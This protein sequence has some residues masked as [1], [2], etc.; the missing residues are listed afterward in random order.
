MA[1]ARPEF[2]LAVIGAGPA[3]SSAAIT[4]ARSGARVVL[5]EAGEFPRHKVCG[6][7]VSAE[8]LDILRDLLQGVSDAGDKLRDAPAIEGVRFLVERACTSAAVSPA[9]LSLPRYDL[10]NLLWQAAQQAG[11]V[12]KSN[13]HVRTIEGNGP[14]E[15]ETSKGQIVASAVVVA[16]G[17]WSRFRPKGAV[18]AGPKWVGLKAHYREEDPSGSSDL[19]FFEYGYCG[20]QPV[21]PGVVNACAM[22]RSDRATSLQEVFA[23]HPALAQRSRKWEPLMEPVTTAPLIYRTPEPVRENLIFVGDAAAF[24]DPFVG[25]GI[26]IALR[27]GRLAIHELLP[28]FQGLTALPNAPA[29][30]KRQYDQQIAPLI[31]AASRI[32]PLLSWPKPAQF[33]VLEFLRLPGVM[34]YLIRRTRRAH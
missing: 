28:T 14:F 17:R 18:P 13:C 24:I 12:A 32:R 7:F 23:L 11:V 27:T 34:P 30:Y 26:S 19:Y 16:A 20:V 10:D 8:A 4:A 31:N 22:V 29:S 3:G 5:L 6:E 33:A 25:D 15:L 2:D 1:V 21:S 9:G